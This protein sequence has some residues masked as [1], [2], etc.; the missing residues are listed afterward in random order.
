M[1]LLLLLPTLICTAGLL[2]TACAKSIDEAAENTIIFSAVADLT[3]ATASNSSLTFEQKMLSAV[4][5]ARAQGR[6]CGNSSMPVVAQLTWN[7]QLHKAAFTHSNNMANYDF[8]SHAGLDGKGVSQR[9]SDA[10]YHWRA[11]G[12]NI[13]AG[14]PDVATV[15][16]G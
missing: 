7:E 16:E 11:V 12:E 10:G 4:N 13:S 9:V 14:P 1:R 2:L 3:S 15:M 5:A 6:K 8:F